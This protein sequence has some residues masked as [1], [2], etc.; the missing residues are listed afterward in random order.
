[1]TVEVGPGNN[2]FI[3]RSGIPGASFTACGWFKQVSDGGYAGLINYGAPSSEWFGVWSG[4][5]TNYQLDLYNS[6]ATVINWAQATDDQWFFLALVRDDATGNIQA[7]FREEGDTALTASA[8]IPA[9]VGTSPDFNICISTFDEMFSGDHGLHKVWNVPLTQAELLLES[10]M[11]RPVRY[12]NLWAWWPCWSAQDTTNGAN[13]GDFLDYSGNGNVATNGS[14][15][16]L[17]IDDVT[18]ANVPLIP[19]GLDSSIVPIFPVTTNRDVADSGTGSDSLTVSA[20]VGLIDSG[21]G[22]DTLAAAIA[23]ALGDGGSGADAVMVSLAQ[24]LADSGIGADS[25]SINAIVPLSDSGSGAEALALTIDLA[26]AEV[27]AGVDA[28]DVITGNFIA[29]ADTGSGLDAVGVDVQFSIADAGVGD[30]TAVV[31]LD[32]SVADSGTGSESVSIRADL[33]VFE[34]ATAL[35]QALI[36]A[37]LQVDD[38]GTGL[39]SASVAGIVRELAVILRA[40]RES[41]V[42]RAMPVSTILRPKKLN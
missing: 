7:F 29:L 22:L 14:G 10:Q 4:S 21:G 6:A 41:N 19:Y 27:G 30:D 31:G 25:V 16:F 28:I 26:L 13:T 42:L 9:G 24:D 1:M 36:S 20:T 32:V 37:V 34:T 39:D 33:S 18:G 23:V 40:R 38:A 35:E 5:G 2:G 11:M 15:L 12:E 8:A 17:N 3:R